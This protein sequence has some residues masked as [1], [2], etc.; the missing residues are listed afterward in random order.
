M[1]T[2]RRALF[3]L[4]A[5]TLLLGGCAPPSPRATQPRGE[6]FSEA[7]EVTNNSP[8]TVEVKFN[9]AASTEGTYLGTVGPGQTARFVLPYPGITHVFATAQTGETPQP[10]GPRSV[11][12]VRIRRVPA[13]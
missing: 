4:A 7:V 8:T 2:A 13:N 3:A 5:F 10:N 1:S 11:R 9:T 12:G 6:A